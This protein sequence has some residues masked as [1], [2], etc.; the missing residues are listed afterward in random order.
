MESQ[1]D[2]SST[3]KDSWLNRSPSTHHPCVSQHADELLAKYAF[4]KSWG[5]HVFE[6]A[7]FFTSRCS[8]GVRDF[9]KRLSF[10]AAS[11][12]PGVAVTCRSPKVRATAVVP[13][14]QIR[15]WQRSRG[16]SVVRWHVASAW[17]LR[18]RASM[19]RLTATPS[20]NPLQG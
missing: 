1:Q 15:S 13:A 12:S 18:G 20:A 17:H 19:F 4:P 10:P 6:H 9:G 7:Y 3:E 16:A 2:S 11:L 5:A 8:S 14:F